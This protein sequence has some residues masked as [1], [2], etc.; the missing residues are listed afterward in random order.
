M[1]KILTVKPGTIKGTDRWTGRAKY[2]KKFTFVYT[3]LGDSTL[4]D[5]DTIAATPGLPLLGQIVKGAY[6]VS[7]QYDE[8]DTHALLWEVTCQ[9]DSDASFAPDDD[10][11]K[12]PPDFTPEWSWSYETIEQLIDVDQITGDLIETAAGEKI[13]ITGPFA[14]P[15]LTIQRYKETFDPDEILLYANRTNETEFW[16]ADPKVA[17]LAGIQDKRAVIQ[18]VNYRLVTYTIKFNFLMVKSGSDLVFTG[19]NAAPLHQG[20]Y[21]K[22]TSDSKKVPFL[23]ENGKPRLGNLTVS[24]DDNGDSDPNYLDFARHRQANLNQLDLGPWS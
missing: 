19:W 12:D 7:K 5:E 23:D 8:K 11:Q 1:P 13:P 24:G 6:C 14:I 20:T 4:D 10:I 2:S 16:G 22:R 3:V 15:V 18:T 21:Y 9:F 17:L